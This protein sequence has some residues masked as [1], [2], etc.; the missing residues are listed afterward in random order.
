[1]KSQTLFNRFALKFMINES[2]DLPF[3]LRLLQGFLSMTDNS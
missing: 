3:N 2:S 1:L